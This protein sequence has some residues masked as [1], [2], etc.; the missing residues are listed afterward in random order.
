MLPYEFGITMAVAVGISALNALTL[1]P[2]LCALLLNPYLDENGEMKDNFAARF[3]KASLAVLAAVILTYQAAG[4]LF[5]WAWV[6][7]LQTA[8]Q[9]F[10]IGVPGMLPQLFGGWLVINRLIRR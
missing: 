3:R 5:E 10:R 1:S 4:T 6:G 7:D 2:A 8:L 9:D